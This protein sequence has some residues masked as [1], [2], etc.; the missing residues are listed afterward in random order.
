MPS[1][2]CPIASCSYSTGDV[3]PAIAAA[4]LTVHNNVHIG[5]AAPAAA[6][7]QKAPKLTRPTISGG[8]SE[9]IWNS[10]QARWNLFRNGTQLTPNEV[11]Q[12]LFQCCDDPLGNDLIRGNPNIV[13]DSDERELLK[14]IKR[15]AVIPVAISV[16]RS[17]LLSIRQCDGE[18]IRTFFARIKGKA[19]TC[20][21]NVDCSAPA[22]HQSVDFTDVI[23]KDV[24]ISGLAE[25]EIK[26]EVLGWAGLDASTMEE[27]VSFLEAKEMAREALNRQS[28]TNA[29]SSYRQSKRHGKKDSGKINC[30]S[31]NVEMEKFTWS[32]RH[33]KLVE[34]K[35]CL[36]CWQKNSPRQ[37]TGPERPTDKQKDKSDAHAIAIGGITSAARLNHML[38]DPESGWKMI[39][40]MA[41]PTLELTI[42]VDQLDYQGVNRSTPN[43]KPS[44]ITVVTDTGAQSCLWGLSDFL[45]CGFTTND[46]IPIKHNLYAANKEK[47]AVLGAVLIRL[48]GRTSDGDRRTAAVM[49]YISPNTRR[50]YL[51]REA[52]IQLGIITKDF[53][54]IGSADESS[55]VNDENAEIN[56]RSPSTGHLT[57]ELISVQPAACGCP[58]RS[59]PLPRP[60]E[61]PFPS[62]EENIPKMREWLLERYSSSTFNQCKHQ[63]LPGMSGPS[64]RL[65]VDPAAK[66]SAVHTPAAVPLHWH[67]AVKDQLDADVA[68]GVIE[69]V[70]L[71]EPSAWCHRMVIARKSDGT[72]RRTV[73][74]SPLNIHCLRETHH[75]RPPFQQA[76]SVPPNTWKSVTDAWNGFHSVPIH[77]DDRHYTTFITPWGR[78][79]YKVAPQG[80]IASGDGY[81]RRFDEIIADIERKSKCVDDTIMWDDDEDLE[82]HW[83]R[84]IDF[85]ILC[86]HNGVVLNRDK[87]QF[88]VKKA[89]FAGFCIT[90]TEL[91]PL[92]KFVRAIKEFPTP[93]KLAD[94]RSWF[95]LINQ[96]GHYNKLCPIM[97]VFKPLLSP[98][99]QFVWDEKLD[100]AFRQSKDVIVDAIKEGVEIFDPV[101]LTCLR[102]D[103]S[104]T[105]IGFLLSQKHCSCK[106]QSPGCCKDGWRIT[107]AGSRF[108]RPEETRYAPVEGEA[109]AIA[110][111]LEQT[112]YFTQGCDNLLIITDHKPLTKLFGDRTL[113]EITNPRLLR[114]KQ[115]TLLWRFSIQYMPGADN[116]FSDATSRHPVESPEDFDCQ[117][118]N[119]MNGL[120]A[121][122]DEIDT[123]ETELATIA[124][125]ELRAITWNLVQAENDNDSQI[126]TLIN[127]IASGFPLSKESLPR[128]IQD[129]WKCRNELCI[130]D[131]VVLY[132]NRIVIPRSLRQEVLQSL[133]SAHQGVTAMN[134]RAKV[135]V[136]W[137]GIT[138]D[139]QSTRDSCYDC[140]RTTPTQ[141]KLPPFEPT[142]PST[143]FEAIASD[144]FLF[145]GWY[146]L[147]IADRLSCWTEIFRIHQGTSESGSSGLCTALR[148]MFSTF[149]V[150][151][152]ISSDGGP[153]FA[154]KNTQAFFKRWGI[155]HRNSSSYSPSSNGRAE[156]AVKS[157]KRLLMTNIS[158][159]GSLDTDKMTRALLMLR[160]TPDPTCK[161]SPAEVIF[162]RR[163]RDSLPGISK[164]VSTFDNPH[165]AR[166]WKEAWNL[167]E[168]S[169]K[170][171]YVR[172]VESLK[173]HTRP[174]EPLRIGDKV[175][176]QNQTGNNPTRWD[177][178]GIV[179]EA[180]DFD[181]YLVKVSGSGRLTLRNRRFL[182][183]FDPHMFYAN[184]Q[185]HLSNQRSLPDVTPSPA[186]AMPYSPAPVGP[187]SET[188]IQP[189]DNQSTP[190]SCDVR[191]TE[192]IGSSHQTKPVLDDAMLQQTSRA[193]V[194][195]TPVQEVRRSTRIRVPKKIY[196][197][198][199]GKFVVK[200]N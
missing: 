168:H 169:L 197:P 190:S 164:E 77:P 131:S 8:S 40:S 194:S 132:K 183:K 74:L 114:I 147:V 78:Y 53:P 24:L 167:K 63:Q 62:T 68:M 19:A 151:C 79:R 29:I 127:A 165:I 12:Q 138:G 52:L 174:L 41:H 103:W 75:I 26:R 37:Q 73:D 150:P 21:Y 140:N 39:E 95:G 47:I 117:E 91:K 25:D 187:S 100:L 82:N 59:S 110:W 146:Y 66:P 94:I 188:T 173:Q 181:Q 111:S 166:R 122:V 81:A 65:H 154:S 45:R 148:K 89:Q 18:S 112:R 198:E 48:S 51:S 157:A 44:N 92:D 134:E 182:R 178:S 106:Q 57:N 135:E 136:Y 99:K 85:I 119:F 14:A 97:T 121:H 33:K 67:D 158:V 6:T 36:S 28:S 159:D 115:R 162:G 116:H 139:I 54:R 50:F 126:Q 38:F 76:K 32:K 98:K 96:V 88:C 11:T 30:Q 193:D 175:F 163:L 105:G 9:E 133:H 46:L 152:E 87:F 109:L 171:R 130:V 1:I 3:E 101:R 179:I 10:F 107:L 15:L 199:T 172:S 84:M 196:E 86:G 124:S 141:A 185:S 71:G 90:P 13:M 123:M 42:S 156:V 125:Q 4:L 128:D 129:F 118:R 170:E 49:A 113:D 83:W 17:D 55:A 93:Q 72:P 143:P 177:R 5:A 137:P 191:T 160:N 108:L 186:H 16:R 161:L 192:Q 176:V 31:C 144:Y 23:V 64:I 22:C 61:L 60:K 7:K 70:P 56:T 35:F 80:F 155:Y 43:V 180:R 189:R 184:Q 58:T 120:R 102:P 104:K 34:R 145:K 195:S 2:D 200:N 20:A 149:G 27:T 69:K 142:I 153:E